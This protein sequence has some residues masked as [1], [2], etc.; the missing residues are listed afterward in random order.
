[1]AGLL[2]YSLPEA[3]PSAKRTVAMI[4]R[5]FERAYSSGNCSGFSPDSLIKSYSVQGNRTPLSTANVLCFG[6]CKFFFE[7]FTRLFETRQ[8][9]F[10]KSDVVNSTASRLHALV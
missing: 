9:L 4:F 2:T 6:I 8:A 3:F 5:K 7:D 1:V 10:Y